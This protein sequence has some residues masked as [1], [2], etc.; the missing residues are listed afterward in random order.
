MATRGPG[1]ARRESGHPGG[2]E[3][4]CGLVP[5]LGDH[6]QFSCQVPVEKSPDL[7]KLTVPL[8]VFLPLRPSFSVTQ[9]PF[10]AQ[11]KDLQQ[12]LGERGLATSGN[13]AVLIDR[14]QKAPLQFLSLQGSD[15]AA[16]KLL[17]RSR[18]SC[19]ERSRRAN[20]RLVGAD[21]AHTCH[22]AD[23]CCFHYWFSTGIVDSLSLIGLDFVHYQS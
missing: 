6:Q 7:T 2:E 13:K 1:R 11:K 20:A 9:C 10:F 3:D 23:F 5:S 18:L 22:V 14:L 4:N 21:A 15:S 12:K 8:Q 17:C 16:S 19:Q